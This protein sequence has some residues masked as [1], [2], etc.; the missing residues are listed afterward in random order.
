LELRPVARGLHAVADLKVVDDELVF[1]D[2]MTRGV[3]VMPLLA[4][5]FDRRAPPLSGLVLGFATGPD[6]INDRMQRLAAAD[7]CRT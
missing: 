6:L 2:A 7:G 4:Y 3:E 5:C 1:R